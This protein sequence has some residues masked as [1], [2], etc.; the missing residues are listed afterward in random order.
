MA[1]TRTEKEKVRP[2][3]KLVIV[4]D[5]LDF[6]WTKIEVVEAILMWRIGYSLEEMEKQLRPHDGVKNAID[7]VALLIMHLARQGKVGPRE[8]GIFGSL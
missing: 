2:K 4:L 6:S 1:C 7:E 5:D 3:D 8:G